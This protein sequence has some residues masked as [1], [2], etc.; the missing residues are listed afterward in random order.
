MVAGIETAKA[1]E[2]VAALSSSNGVA[3]MMAAAGIN[4][5]PGA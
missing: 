4:V 1:D 5:V 2:T 3:A